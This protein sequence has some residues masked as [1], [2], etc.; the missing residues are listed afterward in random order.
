LQLDLRV[1][2]L[3]NDVNWPH[4]RR[5]VI[6]NL[7]EYP[8]KDIWDVLVSAASRYASSAMGTCYAARL[9]LSQLQAE[10]CTREICRIM[11]D[12]SPES[13]D[14]AVEGALQLVRWIP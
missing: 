6:L 4:K 14:A 2:A 13:V 12:D 5:H 7:L 10:L 8:L 3:L 11:K 1:K 9:A